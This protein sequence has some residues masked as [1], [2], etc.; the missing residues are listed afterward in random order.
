[1]NVKTIIGLGSAVAGDTLSHGAAFGDTD[2]ANTKQG[3]GFDANQHFIVLDM[4]RNFFSSPVD[5]DG[6]AVE[7]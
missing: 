6:R 5:N 3:A 4:V 1:M 2:V 7:E